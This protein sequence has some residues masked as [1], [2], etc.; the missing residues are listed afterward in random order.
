MPSCFLFRL[1]VYSG[2][3]TVNNG[4][5]SLFPSFASL[6]PRSIVAGRIPKACRVK[7]DKPTA[8]DITV[9]FSPNY[10][11]S[12]IPLDWLTTERAKV[13]PTLP[14]RIALI[15]TLI[16]VR[17]CVIGNCI[18]TVL[19]FLWYHN[20]FY[21]RSRNK[22]LYKSC[23][24]AGFYREQNAAILPLFNFV[25]FFKNQCFHRKHRLSFYD[26]I[27]LRIVSK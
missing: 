1:F 16:A 24:T 10:R 20:S 13:P 14:M 15:E 17:T 23:T 11:F 4:T 18:W 25:K 5:M 26:Q 21:R 2:V 9:L 7:P 3:K 8:T 19:I 6:M 12:F 22:C 27:M